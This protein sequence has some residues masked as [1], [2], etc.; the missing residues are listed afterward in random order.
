[1][2]PIKTI[3]HE[4]D[5]LLKKASSTEKIHKKF[6]FMKVIMDLLEKDDSKDSLYCYSN[7]GSF[8]INSFYSDREKN[9]II[10]DSFLQEKSF[11]V[12]NFLFEKTPKKYRYFLN[13]N[14]FLK[15]IKG[16]LR[17]EDLDKLIIKYKINYYST[18]YKMMV[19]D[20]FFK[21]NV[22]DSLKKYE[23]EK[24][25]FY[26]LAKEIFFT[27]KDIENLFDKRPNLLLLSIKQEKNLKIKEKDLKD[28]FFKIYTKFRHSSSSY[29]TNPQHEFLMA[30]DIFTDIF[31]KTNIFMNTFAP[32][33]NMSKSLISYLGLNNDKKDNSF[34]K[35]YAM[36]Y[37][38]N[39]KVFYKNTL[40]KQLERHEKIKIFNKIN[41]SQE[42]QKIFIEEYEE[43]PP[44]KKIK[45]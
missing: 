39:N 37:I 13:K 15:T 44:A 32:M 29:L 20:D 30:M 1:M 22:D 17:K 5:D 34:Q 41:L 31:V 7:L 14:D 21:L 26:S 16:V 8:F 12:I 25:N 24:E 4:V 42:E 45:L 6:E 9:K 43:K 27:D 36:D 11:E 40:E 38:K 28:V 23:E 2:P 35:K 3:Y 33:N 18:E 19:M 10:N